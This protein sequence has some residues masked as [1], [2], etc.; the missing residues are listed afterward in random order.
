MPHLGNF[1]GSVLPADV[2]YKYLRM[3]GE[4][5]IFI[6]GSDE[7]G[8]PTELRAIKEGKDPE[9]LAREMHEKIK[10]MFLKFGCTF[11]YYGETHSEQNRHT[12]YTIFNALKGN[13]YIVEKE[14]LQA[15]CDFDKRFLTDR[16]MEGTCPFCK[17]QS[18]RGDQCENCGR[19]LDPTQLIDPRCTICGKKDI[20]F[21]TVKN[22]ALALDK[23]QGNVASFIERT[24]KNNWSKNAIN[25]PLSYIK[26]GLK[27]RD[28]TRNMKWGF[29]VPVKGYENSVFYVWFDAIIGYIGITK[30]W[31]DQEWKRYW[32]SNET[33]LIQFMGKDNIEFH[34]LMW[35]AVLI[36]SN[37]G[38]VLPTTIR[39]SEYLVSKEVK[40]SK[41]KGTGLNME[42]ALG[43]LGA[44]Y[45]RIILMHLYPE[46]ADSEFSIEIVKEVVNKMM[47]DKIGNLV[48][49]VLTI[50][51]AHSQM[52]REI[53][54]DSN[55]LK[56]VN[57]IISEYK[58]S[59]DNMKLREA[60]HSVFELADYGNALMSTH[61]PWALVKKDEEAA[62]T[63]FSNV[64]GTLISI[65]YRMS[66][67]LWP[68]APSASRKA[69]SYLDFR[70]SPLLIDL[71][72][73]LD[74]V[75]FNKD[76]VPIFSKITDEQLEALEKFK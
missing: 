2:Y 73:R 51:K 23:I 30:E 40:F 67:M 49:R 25:K 3:R 48:H 54:M 52:I 22:L 8:T 44:E 43:I 5:V 74:R 33:A 12:V 24:S 20:S 63:E 57:R 26:E 42:E 39:A 41:S 9:I 71:D 64:M 53:R 60:L 13:G 36:G 4:D 1:V 47:N 65:I 17:Y 46:T 70:K 37:L 55:N 38:Y 6:C 28:I 75:N 50:A 19:L 29:P 18:A 15:Y 32:L 27:P 16:L 66:I 61:Q 10:D 72:G 14:N 59:F 34:T 21:R 62:I 31:S 69:L 56:E 7:H 35:P 68:F 45:W 11:T 76:L 58:S